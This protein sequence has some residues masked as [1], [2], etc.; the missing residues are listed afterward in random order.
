MITQKLKSAWADAVK[1]GK[2][3]H[4]LKVKDELWR[5]G[6]K[7]SGKNIINFAENLSKKKPI[8]AKILERKVKGTN[9]TIQLNEFRALRPGHEAYHLGTRPEISAKAKDCRL[10]CQNKKNSISIC[11]RTPLL[12]VKQKKYTWNIYNNAFPYQTTGH[13]LIVPSVK[14]RISHW[15]QQ[16]DASLMEES[17]ALIA[18]MPQMIVV[19]QSLHAGASVNHF[20]FQAFFHDKKY[21]LDFASVKNNILEDYPVPAFVYKLGSG[22]KHIEKA[23]LILQQ[24]NVPFDL[25]FLN[26]QA[27]IFPRNPDHEVVAEFPNGVIGAMDLIGHIVTTDKDVYKNFDIHKLYRT[28]NKTCFEI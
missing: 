1:S 6:L 3:V 24:E 9:F 28:L 14:N 21:A 18:K 11:N 8:A 19:F 15:P 22:N 26:K 25:I 17:L 27:Y 10:F 4:D 20:H 2:I 23:V 13:F 5:I 7:Q 12:Q 16:F